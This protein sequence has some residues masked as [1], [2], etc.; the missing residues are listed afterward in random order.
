MAEDI[1]QRLFLEGDTRAYA[2][3]DECECGRWI[4]TG[5]DL[6]EKEQH[7]DKVPTFGKLVVVD[8]PGA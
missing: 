4:G 8:I 1:N 7:M 3:E 2:Q 5:R 6:R